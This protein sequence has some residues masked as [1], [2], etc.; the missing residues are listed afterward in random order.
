MAAIGFQ[1]DF[2][3]QVR[4]FGN[5]HPAHCETVEALVNLTEYISEK[6]KYILVREVHCGVLLGAARTAE[7]LRSAQFEHDEVHKE[8]R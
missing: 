6:R 1:L 3:S 2:E 8:A 7:I 4:C 5:R